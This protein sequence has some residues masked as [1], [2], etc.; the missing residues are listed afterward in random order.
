MTSQMKTMLSAV[1]VAGLIATPALAKSQ[2][3]QAR[4]SH[5]PLATNSTFVTVESHVV[6]VDPA[7]SIRLG[8]LRD[9]QGADKD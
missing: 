7:P 9:Y 6:G 8:I 3:H 4:I 1:A 2:I 5:A